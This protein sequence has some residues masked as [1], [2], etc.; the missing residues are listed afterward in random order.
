MPPSYAT[1]GPTMLNDNE[2]EIIRMWVLAGAPEEA[3]ETE[4]TYD[5]GISTLMET[6]CAY[7][8]CH[9]GVPGG[10][11]P[12]NYNFYDEILVHLENGKFVERVITLKNNPTL[13]MPPDDASGP[14]NFTQD[15][16][17]M[18]KCWIEK[19]YPEN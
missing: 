17:D 2:L 10:G 14:K 9:D 11:A 1:A 8:G 12:R 13:G 6:H 18:I 19:G 5:S 4:I 7:S 3:S 15:E 16:L